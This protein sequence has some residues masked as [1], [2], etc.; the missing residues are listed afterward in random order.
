MTFH[1][2][3][4]FERSIYLA[5]MAETKRI[6]QSHFSLVVK[7]GGCVTFLQKWPIISLPFISRRLYRGLISLALYLVHWLQH[8]QL[9][10][11]T[12]AQRRSLK[13]PAASFSLKV[14]VI[15]FCSKEYSAAA[16]K[17]CQHQRHFPLVAN[18]PAIFIKQC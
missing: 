3:T 14:T 15:R 9:T 1:Y 7:Q 12:F 6:A 17:R 5:N 8:R 10:L 13:V 2:S 4:S 16:C 18:C 11:A